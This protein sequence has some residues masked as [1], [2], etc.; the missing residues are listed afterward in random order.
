MSIQLHRPYKI[1]SHKQKRYASHY[2]IPSQQSLIV[3]LKEYGNDVSCDIRWEDGNGELQV[4]HEKL[5]SVENI[6]PLN[7]LIDDK[8][9]EI[10]EHY[11]SMNKE[12]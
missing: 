5:F 2:N 1:I 3:P 6:E 9:H 10:W 12:V 4:L 7:S 8:L 11:Y